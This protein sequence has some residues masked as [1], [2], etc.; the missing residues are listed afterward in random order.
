MFL[1]LSL[2][3]LSNKTNLGILLFSL[4]LSL[5]SCVYENFFYLSIFIL[6]LYIFLNNLYKDKRFLICIF[7]FISP[8]IFFQ[9]YLFIFSLNEF[10]YKTFT[11]NSAFLEIYNTSFFDLFFKYFQIL[12]SKNLFT[13]TYFYIFLL[14]FISNL[15]I[16][17]C[18]IMKK[19]EKKF[20]SN[21]EKDVLL[22]SS[23]SLMLFMTTLHNPTIFRFST[24]P[25]IGIIPLIFFIEKLKVK[26]FK[27][28]A[29]LILLQLLCN[30]MI[31][32]KNENNKFFPKFSDLQENV[33]NESIPFF[34]SQKWNKR[35][36][37]TLNFFDQKM[38]LI[39]KKCKKIDEFINFTNDAFIYMIAKKYLDSRQYLYWIKNERYFDVLLNHYDI[40]FKE[41]LI[42]KLSKNDLV[43]FVTSKDL[44]F[45]KK[46][47]DLNKYNFIEAPYSF[48]NKR[49]GILLP[50]YCFLNNAKN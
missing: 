7:S 9:I 41:L 15:L 26:Y 8:I 17:S 45:L 43:I 11:L 25:I 16:S 20:L 39:K 49:M 14:I 50:N 1:A 33:K 5:A 19:I 42:N 13:Q 29:Y 38:I 31:P 23:L 22:I 46:N 30:V 48:D 34:K 12:L 40:D 24:G 3:I 18:L 44:Y 6:P 35:T 10:W 47:Y 28:I 36:W 21:N 37:S 2:F 4:S 32:I 27:P